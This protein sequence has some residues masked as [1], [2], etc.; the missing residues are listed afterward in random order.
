MGDLMR[1]IPFGQLIDWTLGEYQ[2][3]GSVFGVRKIYRSTDDK[4]DVMEIFGEKPEL[5]FGLAAGPHTQLAQN[6]IAGY[7]AG[8][9]FFELKTVQVL[10]G[11]DLPVSKPC[12]L[13]RDEGYN[14]EWS[15]ELYVPQALDE[16]IKAWFALKLL[17]REL[18][19]GRADG[20]VFNMS[21][22]YDLEGIKTGK[23]DS[24]I[25]GL[26]N[27]E[28]TDYW[29]TCKLWALDNL[30]RFKYVDKDFVNRISP[31]ICS[32][33]TLSTLHGCPPEE[34]ER[35]ASYLLEEKGLHTFIKCNPTLLGYEYARKTL[36]N[37]GFGYID[38]DGHHFEND[39]QFDDAVTMI[40]KLTE[41][42]KSLSLQFGV[43]LTN[44]FPVLNTAGEL[45]GEEM[46]M[47]GRSLFPLS[48]EV[49]S[50]FSKAFTGK[51]RISFSGG[52][53]IRNITELCDSGIWPVTI[54][55]TVLKP[56][57]YE[58]VNQLAN[59]LSKIDGLEFKGVDLTKLQA[60]VVKANTELLYH[61]RSGGYRR[62]ERKINAKA[63]LIDC[64]TAPCRDGCPFGQDIQ[65][66]LRAAGEGKHLEALRI[67]TER[68]PMPFITGTICSHKCLNKCIRDY[69]EISIHVR[70]VKL[71]SAYKAYKE[72]LDEIKNPPKTSGKIAVIGGGPAGLAAAYF[73]ARAG[74]FVTIFEKKESLGGI[75]RHVIPEFR[76]ESEAIDNDVALVQ[77]TGVGIRL[78]EEITDL[79]QVRSKGYDKIIIA[80]GAWKP[81]TLEL[82]NGEAIDALDVLEQL[83]KG[84]G[85]LKLGENVV[86]IGGGNT[87]MDAARAVKRVKGVKHVSLVYRRTKLHMPADTEEI[88]S[89]LL[90]GVEFCELLAPIGLLNGILTC[91]KME[92]GELDDSGR[93]SPVP[94]GEFMEIHTD[95]LISA[96]GNNIDSELYK[97]FGITLDKYGHAVI[98]KDTL[99]T[100]LPG[101]Y[102]IGDGAHGPTSVAEVIADAAKCAEAITG[103]GYERYA[104]LNISPD[105]K[106]AIDKKG[107]VYCDDE[108]V[109]ESVRCLECATICELCVDVCPNR[110]NI[111][112]NIDGRPQV[113]H[114]DF[115]C[116]ECGN[117]E[118]FCPYSSAPY[119]D[120]FTFYIYNE[121]F[122]NSENSGFLPQGDGTIKVRIDGNVSTHRDGSELPEDIWRLI[123]ECLKKLKCFFVG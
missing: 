106:A 101:V 67:I 49:A 20:F 98:N 21:V 55:T 32:S 23:I 54:A 4:A 94:T 6:I 92:L 79:E 56:G 9:R 53:D 121:D 118:T 82:V 57:G 97:R 3:E 86:V 107:I 45:P 122:E 22:G 11:E 17:S 99:E 43:K 83:K 2:T 46:Y 103:A 24:F 10:D 116:N 13:A 73:L 112:V 12:I 26:K 91:D 119:L 64:F 47:S 102:V 14:V 72:L 8:A 105:I 68:N 93:R 115:M 15:T 62:S 40:E 114:M 39:L 52:A 69:Y 61:K 65:A 19:L 34:I 59:E 113:V 89:A 81:G 36:D 42:A 50:R 18:Q 30:S 100:D 76:I 7:V 75:V 16:Y 104:A 70:E 38:F 117:C 78:G 71:I 63:P 28:N 48:I 123:E 5:P 96:V 33:I 66:Y 51:L 77:A 29:K 84:T 80:V 111:N 41:R 87:A 109:Q 27:A 37:R 120:K 88:E 25:E 44:T 1:Q 85:D 35:I 31:Q 110:A 74:R 90:D 95:T 60:L 58:R 108:A